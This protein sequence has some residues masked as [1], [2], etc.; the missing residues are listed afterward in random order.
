MPFCMNC[1][2]E[3]SSEKFCPNCGMPVD[4]GKPFQTRKQHVAKPGVRSRDLIF[5][6]LKVLEQKPFRL[7]GLSLLCQLLVGLAAMFGVLPII[8]VPIALVFNA[9]MAA[10]YLAGYRGEE[11]NSDALFAGF[12]R[13]F[14]VA[15]GMGWMALWILI[16]GLIPLAGPVFAIIKSYSYRFVP[17]IMIQDPDISAT[18]ALR[19]SMK[20]TEGYKGRMFLADFLVM[21]AVWLVLLVFGALS[22][23]PRVG[24]AFIVLGVLAAILMSLVL[25]LLLGLINA[26]GYEEFFVKAG[27]EPEEAE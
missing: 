19:L 24:R 20:K 21:L 17:Y 26:A 4:G 6:A 5:K 15:G 8:S 23:I 10:V 22:L 3:L 13:F 18:E 7:W 12:K 2:K 25:P 27:K 16:W 1:G 11:V 9:G 14:K